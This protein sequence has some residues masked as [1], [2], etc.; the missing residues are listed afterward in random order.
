MGSELG[1]LQVDV[2]RLPEGEVLALW[3]LASQAEAEALAR[4]LGRDG[5]AM[6]AV[7]F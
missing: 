4:R 7:D 3:P 6:L 2:L 5:L 1:R